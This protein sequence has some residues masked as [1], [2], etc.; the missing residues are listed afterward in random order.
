MLE[1]SLAEIIR[2]HESLRT[3]FTEQ[4]EQVLQVIRPFEAY[5]TILPL[6]DLSGLASTEIENEVMSLVQQEACSPF[7]LIHGQLLRYHVLRLHVHN[8]ALLLTMHHII[9][10]AWSINIFLHELME[11]YIAFVEGKPSPL[12]DLP[13]QYVDFAVWQRQWLQGDVLSTLVD[14]WTRQLMGATPLRLPTDRPRP[15]TQSNRGAKYTFSLPKQ[16]SKELVLLSRQEGVTLFMTLLAAFQVLLYRYTGQ[17]DIVL[18]TDIAG[19]TALETEGLFGFF[20]NVLALRTDISGKPLFRTL[21]SRVRD[22]VLNAYTHQDL[23]FDLLID[24]LRLERKLNQNPLVQ[25]L[26]VLQ[27]IPIAPSQAR[28]TDI[29]ISPLVNNATSAKFDIA[30]FMHEM[31]D[32]LQGS[33][34]YSTD[35]FDESTIATMVG[36]FEVLLHSLTQNPDIPV[37]MAEMYTEAEKIHILQQ[38]NLRRQ[39]KLK[40]LQINKRTEMNLPP[41]DQMS[42]Q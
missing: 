4:N 39:A 21:L 17:E 37:D 12:S 7:D 5:N 3:L 8:H 24:S 9:S 14:Y 34:E 10:D 33:V 40:T 31:M 38:K 35:L 2:R 30:L 36:R 15:E 28:R 41:S 18:G 19:R 26:F 22:L 23:P 42:Q 20:I 25:V 32:G 1:R 16:L 11:L 27:N 29:T 6:I 13:I